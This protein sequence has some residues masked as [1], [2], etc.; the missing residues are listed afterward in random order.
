[1]Y[2]PVAGSFSRA[3]RNLGDKPMAGNRARRGVLFTNNLQGPA[4]TI[5]VTI[6]MP[7]SETVA[8]HLLFRGT[9]SAWF[10]MHGQLDHHLARLRFAIP[11]V[12]WH[13]TTVEPPMNHTWALR[14]QSSENSGS[15]VQR[16][17]KAV[18]GRFPTVQSASLSIASRADCVARATLREPVA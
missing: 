2:A 18:N 12:A 8:G 16:C 15:S 3:D 9:G 13:L 1:M 4:I 7:P 6:T 10:G 11:G 17:Q 14:V 5:T